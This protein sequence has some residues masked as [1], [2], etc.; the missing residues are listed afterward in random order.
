ML[1]SDEGVPPSKRAITGLPQTGDRS[2]S[3]GVGAVSVGMASEINRVDVSQ[4][5]PPADQGLA[6][7]PLN[8]MNNAG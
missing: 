3:A 2:G 4:S 8:L 5:N 1:P 7:C 6:P